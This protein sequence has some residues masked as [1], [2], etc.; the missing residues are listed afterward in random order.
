MDKKEKFG[1]SKIRLTA[2]MSLPLSDEIV[3]DSHMH[4]GNYNQ[5]Y[6]PFQEPSSAEELVKHMDRLGINQGCIFSQ[7]AQTSDHVLGNNMVI[8]AVKK[9]PE[10]FIGYVFI[11]P[12]YPLSEIVDEMDRCR[13]EGL[14]GIKLITQYHNYPYNGEKLFVVYEY[15]NAYGWP[16]LGHIWGDPQY[17]EEICQRYPRVHFIVGHAEHEY[18]EVARKKANVYISLTGLVDEFGKTEALVRKAGSKNLLYGS[19]CV[20][21]DE[22]YG[23][24]PVVYAK[25][26]DEDKRLILGLNMKRIL[27][28][29]GNGK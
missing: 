25:I 16:I 7:G 18:C 15:A 2:T 29:G 12:N 17:L 20:Y 14:R 1:N 19:D 22:A 11:N 24:G 26:S 28:S 13:G 23:L 9:F 4:I 3:I 6:V 5:Y 8:E 10:R 21:F 27:V